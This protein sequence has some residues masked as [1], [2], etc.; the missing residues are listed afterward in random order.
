[1]D[2]AMEP[3]RSMERLFPRV[4]VCGGGGKRVV[5]SKLGSGWDE[6]YPLPK[7]MGPRMAGEPVV[8]MVAATSCEVPNPAGS[9]GGMG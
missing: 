9:R 6:V 8:M 2:W 1:M 4:C 3:R 5:F 7:C